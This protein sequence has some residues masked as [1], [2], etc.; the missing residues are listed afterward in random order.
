MTDINFKCSEVREGGGE[1]GGCVEG[2]EINIGGYK[3]GGEEAPPWQSLASSMSVNM[4]FSEYIFTRMGP[5]EEIPRAAPRTGLKAWI[6]DNAF[7]LATLSGVSIGAIL[8][9]RT[10]VSPYCMTPYSD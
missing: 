4:K 9:E 8:G 3:E 6:L 5:M 1:R 2:A 7:L 10:K